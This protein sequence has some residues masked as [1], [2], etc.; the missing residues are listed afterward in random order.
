MGALL[1]WCLALVL[2]GHTPEVWNVRAALLL[3][4]SLPSTH[5]PCPLFQTAAKYMKADAKPSDIPEFLREFKV[6]AGVGRGWAGAGRL[7]VRAA[8]S[9]NA[10]GRL[11]CGTNRPRPP[12]PGG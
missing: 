8:G 1:S 11:R 6:G 5:A 4:L 3:E 7:C 2:W 9:A 12:Q 10:G